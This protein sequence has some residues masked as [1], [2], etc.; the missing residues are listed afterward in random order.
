M[1]QL[2]RT[3]FPVWS[4]VEDDVTSATAGTPGNGQIRLMVERLSDG[5]WEWT[6]WRAIR[7]SDFQSGSVL[8]QATARAA[9]ERA[10]SSMTAI[11]HLS[12]VRF[13]QNGRRS[14]AR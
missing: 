9:A 1:Q 11:S 3:M 10:A 4:E 14:P 5:S 8:T 7:P 6:T 13:E 12:P 2:R